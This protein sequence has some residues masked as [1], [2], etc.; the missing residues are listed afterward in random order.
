MQYRFY[1]WAFYLFLEAFSSPIRDM[2]KTL[3]KIRQWTGT[4]YGLISSTN[5]ICSMSHVSYKRVYD[6]MIICTYNLLQIGS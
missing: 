2:Y 5:F 4:V 1:S 6:C 3:Y